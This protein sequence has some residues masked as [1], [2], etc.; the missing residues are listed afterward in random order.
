M[1]EFVSSLFNGFY[2][3]APERTVLFSGSSK[4]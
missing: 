2:P 1:V 3:S 4:R